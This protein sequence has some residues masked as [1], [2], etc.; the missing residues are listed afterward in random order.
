MSH[1][2]MRIIAKF[3]HQIYSRLLID[4][5]ANCNYS[6]GCHVDVVMQSKTCTC[7]Q[8]ASTLE[9]FNATVHGIH[10]IMFFNSAH[11]ITIVFDS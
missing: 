6:L 4:L 8:S 5:I 1:A 3:Y 2:C 10:W 11:C 7:W 9:H